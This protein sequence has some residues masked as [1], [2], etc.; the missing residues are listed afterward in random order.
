MKRIKYQPGLGSERSRIVILNY[1][2]DFEEIKEI[3]DEDAKLILT[4]PNFIEVDSHGRP[5]KKKKESET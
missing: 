2:F 3:K 1:Q 4:N 5:L